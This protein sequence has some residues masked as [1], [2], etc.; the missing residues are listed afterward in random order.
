MNE[1]KVTK[2]LSM[3]VML[4]AGA[5][6]TGSVQAVKLELP[7]PPRLTPPG[8]R[9]ETVS[10]N[11]HEPLLVAGSEVAFVDLDELLARSVALGPSGA[12]A[13][14]RLSLELT[15]ARARW[16]DGRLEVRLTTRG[17]LRTLD[18][19]YLAQG[20]QVCRA[21]DFVEPRL[22]APVVV[23]CVRQIARDLDAWLARLRSPSPPAAVEVLP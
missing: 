16:V 21:A 13:G 9:V 15:D 10:T 4:A 23:D 12:Y 8:L 6:A 11:V 17:T 5:C 1:A 2:L 20:Q 7:P 3:A 14:W 22:G 19:V 18:G